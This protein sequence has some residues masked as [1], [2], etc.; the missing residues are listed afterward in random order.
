MIYVILV[1]M[2]FLSNTKADEIKFHHEW[3]DNKVYDQ[4]I[5]YTN[6]PRKSEDS[7][8]LKIGR[9]TLNKTTQDY[10][11]ELEEVYKRK[12]SYWNN[13]FFISKD[14][15]FLPT[16]QVELNHFWLS[17]NEELGAGLR[18][19]EYLNDNIISLILQGH[20]YTNKGHFFSI[21]LQSSFLNGI[22]NYYY[23]SY[24]YYIKDYWALKPYVS[25]GKSI[26][27]FNLYDNFKTIG[28]STKIKIKENQIELFYD[29]TSRDN[30]S[31]YDKFGIIFGISF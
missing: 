31:D 22:H 25:I 17:S 10:Y 13:I 1:V 8:S 23:G 27:D 5:K 2:F 9:K 12:K 3:L 14:Q 18:L 7:Y 16:Y 11:L 19:S 4:G 24:N 29:K 28:V 15:T 21:K 6:T 30:L 26:E 20:Y